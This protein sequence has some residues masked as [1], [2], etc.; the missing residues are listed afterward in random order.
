MAF[1]LFDHPHF[2]DLLRH[3]GIAELFSAD[4]DIAAMLRFEQ[5]LTEVEAE[6]GVIP[7]EASAAIIASIRQFRPAMVDLAA[8][9]ARDGVIGPSLVAGLR[10]AVPEAI[11]TFVHFGATS[12]DVVDTS[13]MLRMKQAFSILRQDLEAVVGEL[14]RLGLEQGDV[15]IIGRTRMQQAL[16]ITFADRLKS[17]TKPLARQLERTDDLAGHVLAV[18]FGGPVGTLDQLGDKGPAV[19]AALADRLGLSDPGEAWHAARDRI[20]DIGG[21]LTTISGGLGK[22]G[23][24]VALMAQNEVGEIRLEGGGLSSA[25]PYK[26]N[27]IRAEILVALARFNAGQQA[28]LHQSMIHEGERSGAAWTL[29][30]LVLPEMVATTAAS[31]ALSRRCLQGLTVM[32]TDEE[33]EHRD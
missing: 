19:R 29:E 3:D 11:R 15:P 28:S 18:Q 8:G 14:D 32:A 24:D 26:R 10:D 5:A 12:Q 20:V 21:W 33:H 7:K 17:W 25:M 27:P 1:S 23:Q 30:W 4:A 16:P 22:I 13:L 9:V 2:S 6:L 31:L